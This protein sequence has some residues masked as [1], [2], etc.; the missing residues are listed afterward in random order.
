MPRIWLLIG[1]GLTVMVSCVPP[2]QVIVGSKREIYPDMIG[3]N[4]NLTEFDQPW[5][6]D[7][8]VT[9]VGEM[10]VSNFRYPAGTLGNYWDWEKGWLDES[11]PDS[12]MIKWVVEHGLTKSNKRY[13]LENFAKGYKDLGFTP[14]FM[15]NMLSKDLRHTVAALKKADRLGLPVR[16]IE[17]GNEFYFNL[18][19]EMSKYPTPEV[20]GQTCRRWMDTLRVYFPKARFAMIGNYLARKP[21]HT[22]WTRR[23]LKYCP[24]V[25]AVTF[26]KYSP[27]GIDGQQ[28]RNNITAGTEGES[29]LVTATRVCPY[30]E[31][32]L[33]QQWELSL[34][35]NDTAYA[36]LLSTASNA[37]ATYQQVNVP[38]D[39][40]I[41][42]TEFNM[43]DDD[44]AIRGTW[45]NTLYT[46]RYYD[47]FMQS[48]VTL[49]SIHN[50]TGKLFAQIYSQED[51][52]NHIIWKDLT[53]KKWTITA[54]GIA[55]ALFAKASKGM[56]HVAPLLFDENIRIYSDRNEEV[57]LL[58][59]WE[60]SSDAAQRYLLINYGQGA[61]VLDLGPMKGLSATIHSAPL[62][63]Y[64]TSGWDDLTITK[65]TITGAFGCPPHS[66]TL[67]N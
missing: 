36:N 13:T 9:A 17:L 15:V 47:G 48:P 54:Q 42:V 31:A 65:S 5:A 6:H 39:K 24:D 50:V 1:L 66:I 33:C 11:V 32:L 34:L 19:F 8:L 56:N 25:D 4:G 3:L 67:I 55:T 22:D 45:A 28:E 21:R 7:S 18:P 10:E 53:V 52:L 38:E 57:D 40:D 60:F 61:A 59:G 26:H 12:L 44:S 27:S 2:V 43:R 20:Y 46:A 49:T 64:V 30:N 63:K 58:V 51:Q 29:D 62:D 16:Y 14:I 37:A 41:W 35:Q 23:A